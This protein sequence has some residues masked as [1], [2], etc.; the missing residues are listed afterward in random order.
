MII[1]TVK[2]HIEYIIDTLDKIHTNTP[3]ERSQF[4]NDPNAQDATIMRLQDIGE[5]LSRIRDQFPDFFEKYQDDN[6]NKFIGLRNIIS[7]GYREIDFDIIWDIIDDKLP[8]FEKHM[9]KLEKNR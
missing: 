6:W 7:H 1:K 3:S 2:P 8:V 5:Q 9:R 4:L